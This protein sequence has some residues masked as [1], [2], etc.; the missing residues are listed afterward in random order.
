MPALE[1]ESLLSSYFSWHR[2]RLAF[3][4]QLILALMKT[5]T[6][7]GT[8]WVLGV[9]GTASQESKYRRFQRFFREVRF[10]YNGV[11]RCIIKFLGLQGEKLTLS[12]DRTN[13][14]LGKIDL[15]YLVLAVVYRDSAV[16]LLWSL[17]PSC[18]NSRFEHRRALINR[19][20]RIFGKSSLGCLLADRE[21]LDR[22]TLKFMIENR[23]PFCF[24]A[25]KVH[26]ITN[27]A[28]NVR[29]VS[30]LFCGYPRGVVYYTGPRLMWG[31]R[32]YATGM[33]LED[34]DYL[35]LIRDRPSQDKNEALFE[36][37]LRWLIEPLFRF[38]KSSG[39]E[40]EDTHLTKRMRLKKLMAVLA[41]AACWA[42]K[43]GIWKAQ[44]RPIPKKTHQRKAVSLIRYGLNY[45]RET[46]LDPLKKDQI[47]P[48]IKLLSC[49]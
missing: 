12:M 21:F 4:C 32:I 9:E 19:F 38:L 41:L 47:S 3:L 22:K 8:R 14:K 10:D 7:S 49:T 15:N 29:S 23:I 34:G 33:R 24:R 40:L 18:G 48:L 11:A 2:S 45:I 37:R 27:Q 35:V 1:L 30:T 46:L 28:G 5:S 39:F 42:F 13:W 44:K 17:M 6:V 26:R 20:I 25:K 16:P 43:A 31:L 36:Y